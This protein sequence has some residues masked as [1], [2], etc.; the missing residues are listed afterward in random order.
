M[1]LRVVTLVA[2][3]LGTGASIAQDS[4]RERTTAIAAWS[5]TLIEREHCSRGRAVCEMELLLQDTN[6]APRSLARGLAG[7]FL[8]LERSQQIFSCEDNRTVETKG[9]VLI[10][11][12]GSVTLIGN[13]PG[14][15]RGC[16]V[17]GTGE[18]V[19]MVYSLVKNGRPYNLVRIWDS[20][21][22]MLVERRLDEAGDIEFS[23]SGRTYH[24]HVPTP[25]PPG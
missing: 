12:R 11:R 25:E 24:T 22:R 1:S 16:G 15:L 13:H 9:P 10:S 8:V 21:G 5:A 4:L 7:E 20:G 19:L 18:E 14:F 6:G 3:A 2:F 17:T 23:V